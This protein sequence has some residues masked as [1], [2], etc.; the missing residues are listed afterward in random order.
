MTQVISVGVDDPDAHYARAR[1][2]GAEIL[3]ELKDEDYGS[4]G[5]LAR[6]PEGNQWYFRTYRPGRP[7]DR[8]S[9]PRRES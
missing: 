1:V 5:Y 9:L 6:D 7:L 4:R 8:L 3:Q 2:A